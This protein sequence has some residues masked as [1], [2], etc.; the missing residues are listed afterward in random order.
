MN[1]SKKAFKSIIDNMELSSTAKKDL[2]EDL[3]TLYKCYQD[4]M[5]FSEK[6][7]YPFKID[8]F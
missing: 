7:F 4:A 1:F 3:N 5:D 2:K 6:W 8:P